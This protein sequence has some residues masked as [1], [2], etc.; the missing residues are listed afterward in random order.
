MAIYFNKFAVLPRI[1]PATL[2]TQSTAAMSAY[3][4]CDRIRH[5]EVSAQAAYIA[6]DLLEERGKGKIHDYSKKGGVQFT[7][8]YLPDNAPTNFYNRQ[9]LWNA[10]EL[11]EKR[12]DSQLCRTFIGALP[13]ELTV[14]QNIDLLEDYIQTNFT[15]RGMIVDCAIHDPDHKVKNPHVH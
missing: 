5:F 6:G 15:N 9:I 7:Q 2:N 3:Q 11:A 14:E 1:D 12:K 4:A 10:V 8:I 13:Q